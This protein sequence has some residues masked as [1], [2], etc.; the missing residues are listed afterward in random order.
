MRK[1]WMF[2]IVILM[3]L[4]MIFGGCS[5][6]TPGEP[7]AK[8]II[9]SVSGYWWQ[10]KG[11]GI[12]LFPILG[13][14]LSK[15]DEHNLTVL[16]DPVGYGTATGGGSYD[17]GDEVDIK[18]YPINTCYIFVNWTSASIAIDDPNDWSTHVHMCGK[19]I[20]VTANFKKC[21]EDGEPG[22][23]GEPGCTPEI[24]DGY[25]WICGVPTGIPATGPIGADGVAGPIG[26]DGIAGNTPY[27]GTNGNWWIGEGMN[28]I[29]TGVPATGATGE[30]GE[31]GTPGEP[32][33]VGPQGPAGQDCTLPDSIYVYYTITNTGNVNIQEYTITFE[34]ETNKGVY[35]GIATGED[36]AVGITVY[37]YVKI[38]VFS[39]EVVFI[40]YSL[41]LKQMKLEETPSFGGSLIFKIRK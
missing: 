29:D 21:C 39:N 11:A 8:V 2:S 20:T 31:P 1:Q 27:I 15:T 6:T 13:D 26:A 30:P 37:S 24:I 10:T 32:G 22:A 5:L 19:D 18:A 25:W 35:T 16:V 34:A 9:T 23:P 17:E 3:L 40:D 38:D 41:E 33:A 7:S 28:A 36:L 12:E 4:V 14:G